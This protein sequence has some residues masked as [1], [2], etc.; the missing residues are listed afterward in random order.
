MGTAPPDIK[1]LQEALAATCRQAGVHPLKVILFGSRARGDA[2]EHS[3]WDVLVVAPE[4]RDIPF[5]N[6]DVLLRR[7]VRWRRVDLFCYTPEEFDTLS[8]QIGLVQTAVT[9][10]M[11]IT[12][13]S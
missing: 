5:P 8:Q 2:W 1:G 11:D 7:Y 6:R 12:P 3:D 13:T 10:G 9:E 4:F